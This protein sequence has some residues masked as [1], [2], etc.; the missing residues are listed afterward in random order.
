MRMAYNRDV[1][2]GDIN[3]F[4]ADDTI[5]ELS[6]K[7]GRL[8]IADQDG[9]YT[10][11]AK[12]GWAENWMTPAH[13]SNDFYC[14]ATE[15][16]LLGWQPSPCNYVRR[17]D[18]VLSIGDIALGKEASWITIPASVETLFCQALLDRGLHLPLPTNN[19]QD[20]LSSSLLRPR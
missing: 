20:S 7:D 3:C 13:R 2:Y 6:E 14:E 11:F 5:L 1:S 10:E 8:Y 15:R 18:G 12:D 4:V 16:P 17:H 19:R 9:N